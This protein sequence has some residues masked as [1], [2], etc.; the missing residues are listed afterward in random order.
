[1]PNII[2][3]KVTFPNPNNHI[4]HVE[5]C[6]SDILDNELIVKIPVWT[7]GSYLIREFS[8][9]IVNIIAKNPSGELI[10]IDKKTKNTWKID[11]NGQN[12]VLIVYEIYC[13][14]LSVRTC[15]VDEEQAYLNG[16]SLFLFVDGSEQNQSVITFVPNK[17]WNEIST[18][19]ANNEDD[20]W[21]KFASNYYELTDSPILI[22]THKKLS[23]VVGGIPH[24]LA[25]HGISNI[26]NKILIADLTKIIDIEFQLFNT[27]HPCEQY[28][29]IVH[30]TEKQFGG[31]EHLHSSSNMVPRWSYNS[32]DKYIAAISL[33]AHEYFHLWNGKRI[34]PIELGPFDYNQENYTRQLWVVEGLTSYYDN[35]FVYKA[36]VSTK[37]E[38]LNLVQEDLNNQ[39]NQVG[40]DVQSLTAASFDT[41]IKY[42]RPNENSN[43]STVSYYNKGS[44][45]A[46]CLN[47]MILDAT[48]GVK[49][50][51]DVMRLL[52]SN[53]N[54]NPSIGYSEEKLKLV[55]ETVAGISFNDFFND[56]IYNTKKIDYNA[57]FNF[58]GYQLV[59]NESENN[60]YALGLKFRIIDGKC[61][62]VEVVDGYSAYFAGINV[63]DEIIGINGFR[64]EDDFEKYLWNK[65][66][67]DKVSILL[68]RAGLLKSKEM[69]LTMN[70]K[71][72]YKIMPLVNPTEKQQR[73]SKK[74]VL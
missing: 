29:F 27:K 36:G 72:N 40:D 32:R 50:L 68:N 34:R 9:N 8:K 16:A 41:W 19:L 11:T 64:V 18:A 70:K 71:K 6:V 58:V 42:Y 52:W 65:K 5:M 60:G 12:E 3:Y 37:A 15:F 25:L 33:L 10:S 54:I 35:Y 39:V 2:A 51:D 26:N 1:M 57:Y 44:L 21:V 17:N 31:L 59:N 7:P 67:G 24:E 69:V 49:N 43:N 20:K 14:E 30:H 46:I 56:F 62:V 47:F 63:N 23:F 66:V 38:Y 48:D 28:L 55:F 45:V 4:A 22:S 13:F 74:W 73:L 61:I 53:Y